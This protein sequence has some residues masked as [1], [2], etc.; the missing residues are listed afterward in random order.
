MFP[1]GSIARLGDSRLRM[2]W[3]SPS[4]N[5]P[6]G[7]DDVTSEMS[8]SGPK[9]WPPSFDLKT[10]LLK[11]VGGGGKMHPSLF[12]TIFSAATYSV[13]S[14]ATMGLAPMY[15]EKEHVVGCTSLLA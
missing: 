13:P 8:V 3:C 14:L 6:V 12:S 2:N 11:L 4:L 10:T 9:L 5:S 15:C 1:A 7:D